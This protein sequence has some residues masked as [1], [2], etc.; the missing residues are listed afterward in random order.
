V[1]ALILGGDAVPRESIN[2]PGTAGSAAPEVDSKGGESRY[3]DA[4]DSCD[5][6][7]RSV[8]KGQGD[9]GDNVSGRNVSR[10]LCDAIAG[11]HGSFR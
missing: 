6:Q 4:C 8:D 7:L 9:A 5:R 11:R 10:R 2:L 1:V 3:T